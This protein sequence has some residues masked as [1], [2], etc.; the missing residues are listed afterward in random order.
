LTEAL[1]DRGQLAP[2]EVVVGRSPDAKILKAK[3]A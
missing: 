2:D 1:Q 3:K